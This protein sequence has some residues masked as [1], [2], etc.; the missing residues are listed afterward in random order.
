MTTSRILLESVKFLYCVLAAFAFI[1]LFAFVLDVFCLV[2]LGGLKD[3]L[4]WNWQALFFKNWPIVSGTLSFFMYSSWSYFFCLT[5]AFGGMA[6]VIVGPR[7]IPFLEK[8]E[9]SSSG[10]AE[11]TEI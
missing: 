7:R 3:P 6:R 2:F 8:W 4:P 11:Q 5:I 1:L 9:N 10:D